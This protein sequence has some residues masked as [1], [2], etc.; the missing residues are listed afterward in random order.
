[1]HLAANIGDAKVEVTRGL[2]DFQ[3]RV[4]LNSSTV[5]D[6]ASGATLEFNH[7]LSLG[8]NTLTKTGGGTLLVNNSLNTGGGS[9]IASQGVVGGGGTIGGD[10][11]NDG[12]TISPGLSLPVQSPVP[13][14]AS[15]VLLAIGGALLLLR[16]R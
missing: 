3:T 2:H 10:V 12:G 8:G 14:P 5:M 9:I 13:E 6:V 16:R 1:V 15:L 4:V 11:V 7:R